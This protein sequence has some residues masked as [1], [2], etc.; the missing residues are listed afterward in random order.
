MPIARRSLLATAAAL[1]LVAIGR[2]RAA[3][4]NYRLAHDLPPAHPLNV[5]T[6]EACARIRD[7][8][9]GRIE[10]KVFPDSKLGSDLVSLGQV[11]SGEIEFFSV[12]GL[13]L[14]SAVPAASINGV[15]FAFGSYAQVWAAMDGKLGAYVRGEIGKQGVTAVSRMWNN[16]F[17]QVTT[18][19]KPIRTPDDLRGLKLRVPVS[20]LWM[21][22]FSTLGAAPAGLNFV[23]LYDALKTRT[24]DAQENSLAIIQTTKLYEVQGFCSLTNHIWD[25]FWLLANE[26]AMARLPKPVRAIVEEKDASEAQRA[27]AEVYTGAMAA[28][29]RALKRW[30]AVLRNDN[31]AGEYYLTDVVSLAVAE[32]I[33][34]VGV[35]ARAETEVLGVNSPLQLA[36]LERRHPARRYVMVDDKL[37]ILTAMKA[38]MGER[39]TTLADPQALRVCLAAKDAVEFLGSPEGDL[40]LAQAVVYLALAPKSN[41]VYT[42]WK[43]ALQAVE[44]E[45]LAV[46]AHLRNAPTQFLRQQGHGKGYAYYFD[47][48]AGS[49]EQRYLPEGAE[50]RLYTPR[51]EGWEG[52]ASERWRKLMA[53]LLPARCQPWRSRW[54]SECMRRDRGRRASACRCYLRQ[55]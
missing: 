28:P 23:Q 46:P 53:L 25:G 20:P 3:E 12:P 26:Q 8:T 4:F 18:S 39:L 21:S 35:A 15:G 19:T 10:I 1:P 5:R 55:A 34:V 52:R 2:A 30:L 43:A 7:A 13:I 38:V 54:Y 29:T 47:D 44:G 37:R 6:V 9:D 17:R 50:L 14:S 45:N 48:P 27:I 11:R 32:G 31:V 36:D 40:S 22:T 33:P 51:N 24:M 49:F 42:A 16:G 41:S